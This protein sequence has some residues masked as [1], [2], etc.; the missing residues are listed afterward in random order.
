[1]LEKKSSLFVNSVAVF[2]FGVDALLK[3]TITGK[4]SRRK[5]TEDDHPQKLEENSLIVM[6][7]NAL[8]KIVNV[9]ISTFT[10][11]ILR[12]FIYKVLLI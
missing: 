2:I 9:F 8:L 5:A 6:R 7:G 4:K 1:M 11:F 12:K 10:N 3:S